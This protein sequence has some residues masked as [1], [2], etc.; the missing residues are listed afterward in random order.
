MTPSNETETLLRDSLERLAERAP[1][2]NEVLNALARA[3]QRRRR[4]RLALAAAAAAVVAVAAGVPLAVT[5]VTDS[6]AQLTP[7]AGQ[8]VLTYAPDWLPGG[9]TEQYRSGGPGI[10]PQ[11]RQWQSGA[12]RIELAS[13]STADPAWAQTALRISAL[14]DQVVVHG[15]V[16]MVTSSSGTAATLT[17]MPD[18]EHVL[19]A[20]VDGLPDA[21]TVAEQVADSVAASPVRVRGE[22]RFGPLPAGMREQA[23][24]V[25]G[26][27]SANAETVLDASGPTGTVHVTV[28]G[29]PPSLGGSAPVR[30]RALTGAYVPASGPADALVSV[31][32]PSGRWLTASGRV[33]KDQLVAVAEGIVLDSAPDYGWL[34]GS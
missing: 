24:T 7:A 23:T 17:W 28:A 3:R 15:R 31:K 2:G 29:A 5:A 21:R 30:V 8:P 4:P 20:T 11:V 16:G 27:D 32:L 6:T 22:A 26:P 14:P 1:D 18:D 12:S 13:H 9:F 33:P 10:A 25:R 19:T 34:G